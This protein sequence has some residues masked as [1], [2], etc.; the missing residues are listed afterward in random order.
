MNTTSKLL[1][2]GMAVFVSAF[3]T[4]FAEE[5]PDEL[6]H[7]IEAEVKDIAS[8]PAIVEAVKHANDAGMTLDDVKAKDKHWVAT[9]G[10]DDFMESLLHNDA[11]K[12]LLDA[13][14]KWPYIAEAFLTDHNGANVAMTQKTSDYWQGDESKFTDCYTG[15]QG[16]LH[17]GNVD[18]DESSQSYCVHVSLPVLVDGHVGGVLVLSVDLDA[19]EGM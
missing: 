16:K 13:Q 14:K 7:A 15:D 1:A 3:T 6:K 4:S 18:F 2:A 17:F 10:T 5:A 19:F 8:W 9:A 11:A 12:S